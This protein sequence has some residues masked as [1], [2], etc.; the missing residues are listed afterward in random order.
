MQID[1][2]D[3]QRCVNLLETLLNNVSQ[4][5]QKRKF[6]GQTYT[7]EVDTKCFDLIPKLLA[8]VCQSDA[9]MVKDKDGQDT[10]ADDYKCV[11]KKVAQ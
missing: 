5:G 7:I 9:V 11:L 2:L 1:H 4:D 10:R 8:T 6:H 3:A